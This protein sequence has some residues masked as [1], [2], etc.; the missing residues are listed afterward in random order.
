MMSALAVSHAEIC[1]AL[2]VLTSHHSFCSCLN[3]NHLFLAMFPDSDTAKS[4]Q[5]SKTKC[6]YYTVHGLAPYFMEI[7]LIEIKKLSTYSTLQSEASWTF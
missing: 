3:L 2:K 6:T 1:W 5:L 4:I 7:L